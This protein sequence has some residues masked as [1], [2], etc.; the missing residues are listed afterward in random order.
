M[1][2][3]LSS[4]INSVKANK[5]S[6]F[7]FVSA[8]DAGTTGGHQLGIY[9]PKKSFPLLFDQPGKKGQN[10]ERFVEINWFDGTVSNACFKYYGSGT[11]NEYRITRIGI[12]FTENEL[13]VIV[14]IDQDSYSGFRLQEEVSIDLFLKEFGIAKD[15]MGSLINLNSEMSIEDNYVENSPYIN[16]DLSQNSKSIRQNEVS[17]KP[18][19]HILTLLGDE[20][21]KDPVMAI[22]EL[23]KNGYDADATQV[24]VYF[25]SI[26]EIENANI[27]IRDNGTGI[28]ED[29]LQN[30]WL[31]P[32]TAFRKQ[33]DQ[34]GKRIPIRSP[35]FKRIPMG[36]KGVGRFAV[37]K[38]G[39]RI[40]LI[41]RPSIIE[42]DSDGTFI[43]KTLHDYEII[44]EIDWK[45]FTQAK[46]LS[47]VKIEYKRNTDPESF[48]FKNDSGTFIKIS[49]LKEVWNRGMARNLKRNTISMIS[50]RKVN[51]NK[52]EI[53]LNFNNNWLDR[54]PD[55]SEL[56]KQAPYKLTAHIDSSYNLIFDYEFR[57][58]NN[59]TIGSR[60][61]R[62]D[63]KYDTNIA[64][65]IRPL[66]R[67]YF[68]DKGY[69]IVTI[70]YILEKV[71]AKP[72]PFGAVMLELYS[73]DLDSIS[74]K[75][76]TYSPDI[77]KR[78]LREQHG[79]K[80]F[81]DD[82]RV[83]DY[84]EAGND[85]LGL[86]LKRVNNKEWF[87][88]NQ[89]IGF[90]FLDS[91]TSVSLIEKTNREGFVN[92]ESFDLL[93][94][95]LEFI[96]GLFK[97]ERQKDRQQWM[98]FNKKEENISF[99]DRV[100]DFVKMINEAEIED[101]EKRQK[102]LEQASSMGDEYEKAQETLLLP[103]GVGMTAS[104]ALHEIEKLVPRMEETVEKSPVNENIIRN[105]VDELDDY[106]SGIL[107]VLK[108][109]G[110]KPVD[111]LET[112]N[113]AIGNYHLKLEIRNIKIVVEVANN[114]TTINCDKRYLVTMLMNLVDNSIYWLDT[115]Y[116]DPKVILIKVTKTGNST[117]ILV[118]DNGPGFKDSV[119]EIL[120]PFFSRKEGGI[121]IGMYL[122]DTIM[123][124]Y[125][126][127][128]IY[129][130]NSNA[131]IDSS[132]SGAIVELIFNK[133]Q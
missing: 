117:N 81:K 112:I 75:D 11:R 54:F 5:I 37:H 36:E 123:M 84:G 86:D 109:A 115:V 41:S 47:D 78:T 96:L 27:I 128:K 39:S 131:E 125:G 87:S 44:L 61:I 18:K 77:L 76:I 95:A 55:I 19:A 85:W 119:N 88:N 26:T 60:T 20:L 40:L 8:N 43:K 2:D 49:D 42:T 118:A 126:K 82:L 24:E 89:N 45:S 9:I 97:V 74:L 62:N 121:G 71:T 28:T 65:D 16:L 83:Y 12:N 80:V 103:A 34:T 79:I 101:E 25:N 122:I 63:A 50:P 69:D 133:N 113:Q 108:Q 48:Y 90:V 30:V 3:E 111:V 99:G 127:L 22:Y 38:L 33:I 29:V 67:K 66:F 17:F 73:Y 91:E 1:P 92:S 106:V 58:S 93:K 94:I 70:E 124:K 116:K 132:Y 21:I 107:S 56:L 64:G 23:V 4:V 32:G 10:M 110:T 6:F 7:K 35:I 114:V 59:S 68:E 100:T 120:R 14:K 15:N 52:F 129:M 104:V 72:L 53:E 51:E 102:L 13:I 57:L 130:N 46:Y 31:E 105:Q 98:Q